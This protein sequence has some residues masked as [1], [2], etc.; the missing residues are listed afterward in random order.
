MYRIK[1]KFYR[2]KC[3]FY[4]KSCK[5]TEKSVNFTTKVYENFSTKSVENK[6]KVNCL[7]GPNMLP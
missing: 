7:C 6:K 1:C 4:R 2:I 3:K 5:F